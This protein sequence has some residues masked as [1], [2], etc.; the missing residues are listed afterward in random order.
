MRQQ[1]AGDA[2]GE[3]R[4]RDG[5]QRQDAKAAEILAQAQRGEHANALARALALADGPDAS[6][7]AA[8]L[9]G[10]VAA[11]WAAWSASTAEPALR[12]VDEA[13]RQGS[14]DEA[15]RL[16]LGIPRDRL[17]PTWR[18]AA[19]RVLDRLHPEAGPDADSAPLV[20]PNRQIQP[21]SLP[22]APALDARG[23][24]VRQQLTS[25]WWQRLRPNPVSD[26]RGHDRILRG[27]G[28]ATQAP[29]ALGHPPLPT[30]HLAISGE[31]RVR[32][33]LGEVAIEVKRSGATAMSDGQVRSAIPAG[34]RHD[35]R[36]PLLLDDGQL[37]WRSERG[38]E[39]LGAGGPLL[40]SWDLGQG[41]ASIRLDPPQ[42]P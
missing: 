13:L 23:E 38:W 31:G 25:G 27:S 15:E 5:A 33:R 11:L 28:S 10:R 14:L 34:P 6:P 29:P 42:R 19:K 4:R 22:P 32:L 41:E 20:L 30:L 37:W 7:V 24:R 12:R 17:D 35:V 36:L 18:D 3:Q 39:R 9:P 21:A 40:L 1:R 8:A 26:V 16:F 2:D